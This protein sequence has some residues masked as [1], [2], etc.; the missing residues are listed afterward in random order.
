MSMR[1]LLLAAAV[2]ASAL[3][4]AGLTAPLAQEPPAA[5]A[6]DG[7]APPAK[8]EKAVA[9]RAR[10]EALARECEAAA[11]IPLDPMAKFPPVPLF[12]LIPP[13]FDMAPVKK[14]A[15]I[16]DAAARAFPGN[17]RLKLM[18]LRT[19]AAL[20]DRPVTP[21]V[22][23]IRELA[24]AGSS[25]AGFLL[26]VL[27]SA[28]DRDGEA[29]GAH[30]GISRE[31]AVAGLETAAEG[32][33]QSALLGLLAET[34]GGP[35]LK[36]DAAKAIEAARRLETLPQQGPQPGASEAAARRH[37]AERL[38]FLLVTTDGLS[39]ADYAEGFARL[40]KVETVRPQD[41]AFLEAFALRA[42]RGVAADPARARSLL[43]AE[44]AAG[45]WFGAGVLAQ[46]LANGEGGAVEGKRAI[47]L[48]RDPKAASAY[49]GR[50]TLALLLTDNR[51]IG[52]DP[53]AAIRLLDQSRD[54]DAAI[55]AA[56]M[57]PDWQTQLA[58][59]SLL[60]ERLRNAAEA[61]EP[62]AALA[63]AKLQLSED[64]QFRDEAAGRAVLDQ[65]AAAGDAE[66]AFL[67]AAT[68]YANLASTSYQ[69][70]RRDDGGPSDDDIRSLVADGIA[71]KRADAYLL[72]AKL[73][74]RGV[75]Y[76]Q[77]DRAATVE[78]IS[79]ANLGSVEAMVLLGDAY[80]DGLGTPKDPHERLHAWREAVK[81]GSL[82]ARRKIASAFTFDS[83]DKLITLREGV[84]ERIAM[85][86]LDAGRGSGAMPAG[87]TATMDL[88]GLFSSGRAADAGV[89][90]LAG[91]VI[92]GYRIAPS[93]LD[94]AVLV[95]TLKAL[96]DEIRLAMEQQLASDGL[97]KR[98]PDGYFSPD[99]RNALR[100]F[101]DEK[102]PLP[103]AEAAAASAAPQPPPIDPE[104]LN[105]VRDAAFKRAQNVKTKKERTAVIRE[106]NTL[107]R[108]GDLAA[109][110]ALVSNYHQA[111]FVRNNVTAAEVTRYG[112]DI[113]VA[114]P[115][116]IE[117]PDF[118]FVFDVTQI[119]SDGR[120]RAFGGAVI[121]AIRDDGRMQDP[122]ALG[123]VLKALVFAP[124]ACDAI[125][126]AAEADRVGGLGA[127][128]CDETTKSA[129]IAFAAAK[130]PAGVDAAAREAAAAEILRLGKRR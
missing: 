80:D 128:G 5:A 129:L 93:G 59:P 113:L 72:H 62:G 31:E 76:P 81:R 32:G 55:V 66:A 1:S 101:V 43:E 6:T 4:A 63:L 61:G 50:Q 40:A 111:D 77:D 85:H 107:A 38:T 82:E 91:A 16:C 126:A 123:G 86:N 121:A 99:A 30:H 104:L 118:A 47:Q 90:A 24:S 29:K 52:P 75:L 84:S 33:H 116:G 83:F 95:P 120:I 35:L 13:D 46:M 97:L 27:Y 39:D 68:Q 88:A 15:A 71:A 49:K 34:I 70:Y 79:A 106:L 114:R 7:A 9:E 69:P 96:P 41:R 8:N 124:G 22:P 14:L 110:W 100:A 54:I 10:A 28:P 11:A 26:Y 57:L 92:D 64:S 19:A 42:G 103:A 125:L 21:L 115:A 36:R 3:P 112:L 74:R 37:G 130:G 67:L 51:F 56:G 65:A 17:Q 108:Y 25:E 127:D 45:H 78:L 89:P 122:L 60:L 73:L 20:F 23:A 58:A 44:V 18:A 109:R 48:L 12:E 98:P 105:R 94:E 102:G 119:Q 87:I 117:K 2:F 53:H